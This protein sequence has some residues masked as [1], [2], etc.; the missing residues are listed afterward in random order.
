MG[1][2]QD[3]E[4]SRLSVTQISESEIQATFLFDEGLALFKGHFPGHPILPGIFQLEMV[5]NVMEK[6]TEKRFTIQ[7]VKKTKFLHVIR[8]G[9]QV[10]LSLAVS[11]LDVRSSTVKAVIRIND[12]IAGKANLVLSECA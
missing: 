5:K 8:P 6:I 4:K 3:L 11:F 1:A 12:T 10:A 9:E 7:T 2:Y